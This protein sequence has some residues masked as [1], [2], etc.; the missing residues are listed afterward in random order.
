MHASR[1]LGDAILNLRSKPDRFAGRYRGAIL[2]RGAEI[3]GNGLR[4]LIVATEQMDM[5]FIGAE[6]APARRALGD[7]DVPQ[8]GKAPGAQDGAQGAEPAHGQENRAGKR[9]AGI[10]RID[11]VDVAAPRCTMSVP[12]AGLGL[13]AA[14]EW[15]LQG[16]SM[17]QHGTCIEH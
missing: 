11:G 13:G 4:L 5:D 9:R 15:D 2:E 3:G 1:S 6:I 10:R 14:G 12:E 16:C 17:N 8:A 7:I